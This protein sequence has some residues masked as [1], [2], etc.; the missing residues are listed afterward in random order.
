M[1]DIRKYRFITD[2]TLTLPVTFHC[3]KIVN[4]GKIKCIQ[5]YSQIC[6]YMDKYE[7]LTL[8]IRNDRTIK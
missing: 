4:E 7:V 6:N 3:N 2:F 1:T 8:K 5:C